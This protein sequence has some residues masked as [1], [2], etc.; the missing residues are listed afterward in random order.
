MEKVLKIR[1]FLCSLCSFTN[2]LPIIWESQH[3]RNYNKNDSLH[4]RGEIVPAILE[5]I[6]KE[7]T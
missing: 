5:Y 1:G 7:H 6:G 4:I 3:L 2:D